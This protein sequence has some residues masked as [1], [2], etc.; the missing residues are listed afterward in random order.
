MLPYSD[1]LA[2]KQMALTNQEVKKALLL[3]M[4]TSV[5]VIQ[6]ACDRE[7]QKLLHTTSNHCYILN[8]RIVHKPWQFQNISFFYGV[9][10]GWGG[11]IRTE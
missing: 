2:A 5:L 11:C 7:L 1:Y 6:C 10:G 8:N 9:G 3:R 4:I